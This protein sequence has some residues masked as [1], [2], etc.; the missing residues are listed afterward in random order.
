M[1]KTKNWKKQEVANN[2][3]VIAIWIRKSEEIS[4]IKSPDGY[5]VWRSTNPVL[6]FGRGVKSMHGSIYHSK[7]KEQALKFA[8][9][10]MR[11]HPN[12]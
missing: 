10:F 6:D 5:K 11:A 3:N 9:N 4:V 1:G 7:S 12:G 8:V 2:S